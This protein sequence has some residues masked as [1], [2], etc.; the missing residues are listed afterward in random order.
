MTAIDILKQSFS[1][2][3]RLFNKLFWI[4]VASSIAPLL[5]VMTSG[6]E[7]PSGLVMFF[8]MGMSMFFSV[9]MMSLIHQF[10]QTKD[11]SLSEAFSL[12]LKKVLPVTLTGF[13]FG[14]FVMLALIPGAIVGTILAAGIENEHLKNL[15]IGI[16][17]AIPISLVMY[18]CFFAAYFTL[19]DDLNPFEAIKASNAQ[20]KGNKLIF[21][22]FLVLSGVT[23]VYILAL[24]LLNS[25]IAVN[26][27]ALG[28]LEFVL[29]VL[30]MPFFSV[31]IYRL[32]TVT[33]S[34]D[35]IDEEV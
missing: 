11:D 14:I 2:Y 18:R 20:V 33:K 29:N 16:I 22:G 27:V 34:A 21:R 15:F 5:V 13:V 12:T 9:Y 35:H 24:M 32:F 8:I 7:R 31:F 26:P 6:T 10:S 19:V 17:I 28:F 3:L 4:S 25:M 30:A 1:F 23:L